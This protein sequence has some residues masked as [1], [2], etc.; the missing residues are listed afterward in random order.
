MLAI[1]YRWTDSCDPAGLRAMRDILS[2]EE[3]ARADRFKFD[4]DRRDFVA[5]HAL[6]RTALSRY[7]GAPPAQFRF[8]INAYGK[9]SLP[10]TSD[11]WQAWK[12]SVSHTDGL[13]ACAIA[14][15]QTAIGSD[16]EVGIDV[17]RVRPGINHR[18]IA[19]R[20]FAPAERQWLDACADEDAAFRF[21]E[22][23]TLKEASLKAVGTG[24]ALPLDSLPFAFDPAS[25]LRFVGEGD[26]GEWRFRLAAPSTVTRLAVAIRSRATGGLRGPSPSGR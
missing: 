8:E 5:A 10:P 22:L 4:V 14:R 26:A 11:G 15:N 1:W 20:H 6:L 17:E 21:L 3:R 9:P 18:A 16:T 25:G 7:A 12:F 24:L 2:D 23:W 19:S 13:V